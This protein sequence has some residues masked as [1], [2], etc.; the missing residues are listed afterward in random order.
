MNPAPSLWGSGSTPLLP[1]PALV[2]GDSREARRPAWSTHGGGRSASVSWPPEDGPRGLC[3]HTAMTS[4][5]REP[6]GCPGVTSTRT[7][8]GCP[9]HTWP[10]LQ[11]GWSVASSSP[12]SLS[13]VTCRHHG[14][15]LGASGKLAVPS[16]PDLGPNS[17]LKGQAE[18]AAVVPSPLEA[19]DG[20]GAAGLGSRQVAPGHP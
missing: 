16:P 20:E 14:P 4:C 17:G 15:G 12:G 3:W 19:K 18:G 7:H 8:A 10:R 5:R 1:S 11:A 9:A 6:R 2:L 13:K